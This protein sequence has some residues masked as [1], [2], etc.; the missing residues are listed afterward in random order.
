MD[1]KQHWDQVYSTK[2]PNTVRW[3]QEHDEHSQRLIHATGIGTDAA[4]FDIWGG[5]STLVDDLLADRYTNITVL[6]LSETALATARQRIG[7]L[8]NHIHLT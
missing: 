6:D 1:R 2:K 4:I 3:L 8:A 7:E 5:A